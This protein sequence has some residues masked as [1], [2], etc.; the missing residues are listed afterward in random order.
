MRTLEYD[1]EQQALVLIDQTRLP[2]ESRMVACRTAEE[3]AH[4]IRSMQVRGAPAIGVSAAY[5]MALGAAAY[6][7]GD[8]Q[9]FITHMEQC[10]QLLRTTRPTAVNLHWALDRVLARARAVAEQSGPQAAAGALLKLA[11]EMAE[12]D[13]TANRRMGTYGLDLVP[14][15]ANVLTHCNTGALAT[16]DYGT[17][18]GVVRAAHEAGRGIHVYVDETRPFLQ[19]ARLTA[20]ELQQ[21][22]VPM[23]L[24]TD[25]MAG[26]FMSRGKVDLVVVGADRIA[27]NGDVANK[28]GTYSLAV[29]AREHGIPFYVA[30]PTSTIDLSLASGAEIPIEERSSAEVVQVFSERIAPEGVTAAHPAFDVTPA[31]LVTAIV[32]E[33]GV[34]RAPYEPALAEAVR[35]ATAVGAA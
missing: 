31:R 16:V 20:W 29:L 35:G 34:L 28:I 14:E 11:H 26:H 5:G 7:G 4:A 32:T 12:E 6:Q 15:N 3:V 22:G 10:D 25:S 27:A 8:A 2:L 30:A 9:G 19:G 23:T 33:R 13:V 21:L 17:A 24:I 1:Q 18:L